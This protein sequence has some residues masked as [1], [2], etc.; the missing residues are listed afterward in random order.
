M[1]PMKRQLAGRNLPG[2]RRFGMVAGRC[3]PDAM[4]RRSSD[5]NSAAGYPG[6]ELKK[7]IVGQKKRESVE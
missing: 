3:G 7:R 2:P 1:H 6:K 4:R 5:H